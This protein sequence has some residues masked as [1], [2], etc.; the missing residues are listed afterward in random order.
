MTSLSLSG[1]PSL[2][3]GAIVS[4]RAHVS[5]V[6]GCPPAF[7]GRPSRSGQRTAHSSYWTAPPHSTAVKPL[8]VGVGPKT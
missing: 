6:R 5:M 2:G 8:R 7:Q 3:V 4:D 1:R